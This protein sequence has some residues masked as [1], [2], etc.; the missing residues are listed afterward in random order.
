MPQ[1]DLS[2]IPLTSTIGYQ[3][4]SHLIVHFTDG[5]PDLGRKVF[6]P[7]LKDL[8]DDLS[9][10]AVNVMKTVS[11]SICVRILGQRLLRQIRSCTNGRR[12]RKK[13][14]DRNPLSLEY[15]GVRLGLVSTPQQEQ[16]VVAHSM[17]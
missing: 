1:G 3:A 12:L 4:N 17:S 5:N 13:F 9:V 7:E 8:A 16:D 10:R 11:F 15:N 6:Q 2:I 14:R